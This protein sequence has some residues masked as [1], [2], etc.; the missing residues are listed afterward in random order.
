[1]LACSII[2]S[3]DTVRKGLQDLVQRNGANELMIVSDVFDPAKRL[4]SFEMIAECRPA[5]VELPRAAAA[6]VT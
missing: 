1:M 4:R 3:P 2:G 5:A 6:E